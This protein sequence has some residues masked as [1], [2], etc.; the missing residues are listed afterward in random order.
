MPRM[1]RNAI[2]AFTRVFDALW[3]CAADPGPMLYMI[4]EFMGPGSAVQRHRAAPRPGHEVEMMS[5]DE[6]KQFVPLNIAVLTISDTR[7]LAD[8]K[9]GATLAERIVAAGHKL[10]AREIIVDDVEAIRVIV[11]RWIADAGVDVVITTGGTGFTGRDVT[12]EAIEPLFEKRMDGFAIA[13]HML[14]HGKIG[15]STIQSRATAGVAGATFIFC[16]P[17]SPGACRDGWDGIL[18]PQ[19]DYRT[20]PCNFVEI[21]P[22]LDEHLRR[23]K[24]GG[25][26]A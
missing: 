26:S 2:S 7:S 4:L 15:T 23:P 1:L 19:L 14:S 17:G 21:M 9:S 16:L 24:A 10:A 22:R 5:I 6:S 25:A 18:G 13:F 3:C 8:D 11:K 12:P 20:R